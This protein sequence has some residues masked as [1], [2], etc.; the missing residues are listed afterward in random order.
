M[1]ERTVRIR[2][3]QRITIRS[4]RDGDGAAV[5]DGFAHLS[6]E[7]RRSRFFSPAPRLAPATAADLTKVDG[8]HL[9]LLAFDAG[10]RLVGGARATRHRDDRSVAEVAVTVGD[11][12]QRR[13]LGTKLLRALRAD[14]ATAGI[15]RLAGHVLID[16]AAGQALL[17]SGHAAVWFDEP[18][19]LGFEIPLGRRTVAPAVAAR[20][21][22]G[23]AS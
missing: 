17:V 14:A 4:M 21:T 10:D 7:S 6:A 5:L 18:G 22:L 9:V 3:G 8:E 1:S 11:P 20:R 16:D 19:V 12:L 13:G 2:G 15:E 23:M